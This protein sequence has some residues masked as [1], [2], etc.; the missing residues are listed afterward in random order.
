MKKLLIVLGY[1]IAVIAAVGV[2]I[3]AISMLAESKKKA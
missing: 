3:A 2:A 1:V